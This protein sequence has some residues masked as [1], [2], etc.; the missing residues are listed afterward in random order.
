MTGA[1]V[2]R[3][4]LLMVKYFKAFSILYLTIETH[5]HKHTLLLAVIKIRLSVNFIALG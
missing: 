2:N 4:T 5:T 3:L 1:H